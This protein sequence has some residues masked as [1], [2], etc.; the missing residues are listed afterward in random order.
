MNNLETRKNLQNL[1]FRAAEI[2]TLPS[3]RLRQR[4]LI[5]RRIEPKPKPR[6]D[7]R[8]DDRLVKRFE[9]SQKNAINGLENVYNRHSQRTN[10]LLMDLHI[11]MT[12]NGFGHYRPKTT[13]E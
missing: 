11:Q 4:H 5:L 9:H 10:Q 1:D 6:P 13:D 3:E 7:A 8:Q 2:P 12:K